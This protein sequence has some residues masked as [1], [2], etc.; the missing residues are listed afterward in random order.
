M[1]VAGNS[2]FWARLGNSNNPGLLPPRER[3]KQIRRGQNPYVTGTP[4]PCNSPVFFGRAQ[5]L[6]EIL[7]VL[8]RPEKPG[9]VSVLGERRI[10]KSSLLNQVFQALAHE[11]GLVAIRA[12][13]QN[14]SQASQGHFYAGLQHAI[15]QAADTSLVQ[16]THDYPG[17]RDFIHSLCREH[18]YRFVLILDEFEVMAGNPQFD[19]GFFFNLRALGERPEYRFRYLIASRRPLDELSQEHRIEAS[20]FWNIFGLKQVLG[21]LTEEEAQALITE[22]MQRS[23]SPRERPDDP[24][25]LWQERILPFTGHHPALIQMVAA[26]YWDGQDGGYEPD[27]RHITMGVRDYPED[28]W[29]RRSCEEKELLI[30]AAHGYSPNTGRV[31]HDMV[32]RDLLTEQGQP[33]CELFR[34][35]IKDSLKGKSVKQA[36]KELKKECK[37]KKRRRW[38]TWLE[39]ANKILDLLIKARGLLMSGS[40]VSQP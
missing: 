25:R 4:L 15:A 20:S 28:L 27:R 19:A 17:F 13:A 2:D 22:P 12:T 21:L 35:V 9:C 34:E 26:S 18:S 1:T 10:G 24:V 5:N 6:H 37:R 36:L 33:F 23:L 11:P 32:Q 7:S 3:L 40:K 38:D 30:R 8:R 39:W 16:T 29:S 31:F 14:W